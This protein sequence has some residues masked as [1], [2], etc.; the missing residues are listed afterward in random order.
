MAY[1]FFSQELLTKDILDLTQVFLEKQD[2]A[3]KQNNVSY[4][5]ADIVLYLKDVTEDFKFTDNK[6]V[7]L[8]NAVREVVAKYYKSKGEENPFEGGIDTGLK[9]FENGVVPRE[10]ALVEDGK[11]KGMGVGKPAPFEKEKEKSGGEPAPTPAEGAIETIIVE[12]TEELRKFKA[13][14]AKRQ[15]IMDDVYDDDEKKEFIALMQ[16][17]LD[18]DEIIAEDGDKYYIERVKVLQEFINK[19]KKS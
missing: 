18:A 9:K 10:A 3:R 12:E 5:L 4:S 19:N 14:L 7:D 6:Y 15:E 13:E 8:D 16:K 2:E 1:K 11:V 17:K